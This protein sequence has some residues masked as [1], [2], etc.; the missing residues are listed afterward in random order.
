MRTFLIEFE[1]TSLFCCAISG[2][3]HEQTVTPERT[4]MLKL[5][6]CKTIDDFAR[7]LTTGFSLPDA[8]FTRDMLKGINTARSVR[9]ADVARVLNEPSNLHSTRNRLSRN[10]ANTLLA[11]ELSDRLLR[12]GAHSV[13]RDTRLIVRTYALCKPDARKMQYLYDETDPEMN[14]Y[15]ICE[16]VASNT[17]SQKYLPLFSTFWSRHAPDY[18]SDVDEIN[19]AIHRVLSVTNGRGIVFLDHPFLELSVLSALVTELAGDASVQ[20]VATVQDENTN[21]LRYRQQSKTLSDLRELCNTPYACRIFKVLPQNSGLPETMQVPSDFQGLYQEIVSSPDGELTEHSINMEFGS[22]AV[23]HQDSQRRLHLLVL[24]GEL[25]THLLTSLDDMRTRG[26]LLA[27]VWSWFSTWEVISAHSTITD[28]FTPGDIGVMTYDR[29]RL[30]L[31]LLHAVVFFE[32]RAYRLKD[33]SLTRLQP[34]EGRRF[35][36]N[37]LL[38]EDVARMGSRE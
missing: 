22:L 13:R 3:H 20:F 17:G 28:D 23:R 6:K 32:A 4:L 21:Q 19:R 31:T 14:S 37:F 11:T 25:S 24:K 38:P 16:I 2:I 1:I 27:P 34:H 26:S 30:L 9:L 18:V 29:M 35:Q 10:L 8:K 36:R 33:Y 12:Q 15:Q 7:W 5:D